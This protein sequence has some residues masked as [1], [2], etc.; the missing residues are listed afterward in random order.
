MR[1]LFCASAAVVAAAIAGPAVAGGLPGANYNE[2]FTI[3]EFLDADF[4]GGSYT[5]ELARAYQERAAY[6]ASYGVDGDNNWYDATA[7]AAKGRAAAN[8]EEVQPWEP[9]ELDLG[10]RELLLARQTTVA[11]AEKYK[12]VNPR[13]CAQMVAFYDHFIEE[14]REERHS[15]TEP[16]VM[17]AGWKGAYADCIGV[18][19]IYGY[20]VTACQPTD[21]DA[22]IP[23]EP[24]KGRKERS[25]AIRI[26]TELGAAGKSGLLSAIA[27]QIRV[28]GHTSTTGSEG[29]NAKLSQC[30]ADWIKGLMASKG[31]P[32]NLITA[33]ALGETA[34]EVQ[35]DDGVEEY[36]NRRTAISLE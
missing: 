5:E 31:V 8:G 2:T 13:G 19:A 29:R 17:V 36:R 7:F 6:E 30:R 1:N 28:A 25:E 27:A 11:M 24:T 4:G 9:V 14:V 33:E 22:R 23:D 18:R 32:E 15:I 21:R 3:Q 20:A 35:T 12:Y 10:A 26:A 16:S 34:L